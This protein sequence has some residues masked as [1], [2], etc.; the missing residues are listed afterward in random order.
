MKDKVKAYLKQGFNFKLICDHKEI[1]LYSYGTQTRFK[2][3]CKRNSR[4]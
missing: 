2:D 3:N 4:Y 1:E